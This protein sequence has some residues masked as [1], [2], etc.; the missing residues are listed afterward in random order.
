MIVYYQVLL[1]PIEFLFLSWLTVY[2][3]KSYSYSSYYFRSKKR[4]YGTIEEGYT[5]TWKFR[6]RNIKTDLLIFDCK[7]LIAMNNEQVELSHL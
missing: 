7:L 5:D 4:D 1:N 6:L 3:F 2:V